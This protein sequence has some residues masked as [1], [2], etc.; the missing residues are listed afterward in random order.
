MDGVPVYTPRD[1]LQGNTIGVRSQNLPSQGSLPGVAAT[2]LPTRPR[3]Q[4]QRNFQSDA[5]GPTGFCRDGGS[6]HH[7]SRAMLGLRIC[8]AQWR[9]LE[10]GDCLITKYLLAGPW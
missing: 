4:G 10:L 2:K 6:E 5:S 3:E 8:T 7:P 1:S 9:D